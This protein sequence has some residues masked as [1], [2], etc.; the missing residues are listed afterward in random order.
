MAESILNDGSSEKFT[1]ILPDLFPSSTTSPSA[2][3]SGRSSKTVSLSSS[4]KYSLKNSLER[5]KE[6]EREKEREKGREKERKS[7]RLGTGMKRGMEEEKG[8]VGKQKATGTLKDSLNKNNTE[9]EAMIKVEEQSLDDF[10]GDMSPRTRFLTLSMA[11]SVNP[12]IPIIIRMDLNSEEINLA[13]MGL[14]DDYIILLSEVLNFILFYF[15]L[16]F[17]I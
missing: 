10:R 5:E 13:N 2:S 12:P 11:L 9:K 17:L 7:I 6:K 3:S 1:G 14:K 15:I 8:E 16:C 4:L